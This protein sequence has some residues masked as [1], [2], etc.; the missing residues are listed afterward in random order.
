[1]KSAPAQ[2]KNVVVDEAN[3]ITYSVLA[4]RLLTDG[5]IYKAIRL[6]L[7]HRN[8]KLPAKGETLEISWTK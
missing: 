3:G 2:V 5:E 1:M 4:N 7:L 8:R 6:A